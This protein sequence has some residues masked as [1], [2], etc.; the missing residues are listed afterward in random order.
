MGYKLIASTTDSLDLS[1]E[2][3][4]FS[5]WCKL[6]TFEGYPRMLANG[7]ELEEGHQMKTPNEDETAET[8][9]KNKFTV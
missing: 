8:R 7:D 5:L 4:K 1:F 3:V 2:I 9:G 6:E